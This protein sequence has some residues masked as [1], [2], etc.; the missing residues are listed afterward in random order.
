MFHFLP[1]QVI[2]HG[3]KAPSEEAFQVHVGPMRPTSVGQIKLKNADPNA[4]PIIDP[5]YLATGE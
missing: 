1:S 4:Y 3:R 5:N 2:D